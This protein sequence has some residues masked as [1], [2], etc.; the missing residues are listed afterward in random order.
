M[1][2][3]TLSATLLRRGIASIT[4]NGFED[5]TTFHTEFLG[6][7]TG[8]GQ[9]TEEA[10]HAELGTAQRI[11]DPGSQGLR[12]PLP[13]ATF[14]VS[15]VVR[16]FYSRFGLAYEFIDD[17]ADD[18]L[19]GIIRQVGSS[20]GKSL[21]HRMEV[22]SHDLL[23]NGEDGTN[24]PQGWQATALFKAGHGLLNSTDTVDNLLAPSG[25]SFAGIANIYSYGD[26]F[27]DDQGMPTP[28]RP[29]LILT[30]PRNSY[31]WTQA[32][33]SPTQVGQPNSAVR[34]PY[35]DIRVL[36]S[37]YLSN[38]ND[39]Y[40]FYE[41]HKEQLKMTV[42]RGATTR[43]WDEHDPERTVTSI[44]ARWVVYTTNNLRV[45]KIPGAV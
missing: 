14:P 24:F 19:Y 36:G 32:L 18:D 6:V 30:G 26:S 11:G 16:V 43:T 35:S 41:G 12:D 39:T 1:A 3:Q 2:T 23:N 4:K 21:R 42:R 40:V 20:L 44:D 22:D 28:I 38:P 27:V 10:F 15:P 29:V 33:Q 7:G 5:I 8:D 37:Q 17:E 9:Y 34:N 45:V 31:L 13:R 25:P